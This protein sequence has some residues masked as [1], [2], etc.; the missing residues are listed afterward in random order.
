MANPGN[1]Q[2]I[3][4]FLGFV[5]LFALAFSLGVI[6][7]KSIN[8]NGREDI[9]KEDIS[10]DSSSEADVNVSNKEVALNDSTISKGEGLID[11]SKEITNSKENEDIK[12]QL[13]EDEQQ[14]SVTSEKSEQRTSF[15]LPKIEPGGKYTV[16]VGSFADEKIAGK[17][18]DFFKS[19][20]Y[21]AFVKKVDIPDKGTR[22]RVRIGEFRTKNSAKIYAD[23]LVKLEPGIEVAFVTLN[24]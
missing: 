19:K 2:I 12:T 18:T 10:S 3:T 15:S 23:S 21:P 14:D 5:V 24:D 7:G 8:D 17:R 16:Q 22:Y 6:V 1:R 4:F 9:V 13:V 11:D 20:G